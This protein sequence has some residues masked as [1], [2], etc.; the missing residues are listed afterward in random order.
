MF[1]NRPVLAWSC[2]TCG[3][4][5][6]TDNIYGIFLEGLRCSKINGADGSNL[7]DILKKTVELYTLN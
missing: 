7:V 4:P 2:E 3:K 5:G 6:G 1:E